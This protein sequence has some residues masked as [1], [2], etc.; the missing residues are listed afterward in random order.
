M[1]KEIGIAMNRLSVGVLASVLMLGA[2][3][4]AQAAGTHFQTA[5]IID[6]GTGDDIDGAATLTRTEDAV[7]ME[8]RTADLDKKAGYTTWWVIFNNPENCVDGCGMDDLGN[9]QVA[10]SIFYAG[11]FITGTDGAANVTAH[12]EAGVLAEGIDHFFGPGLAAGNGLEAECHAIV[13]SHGLLIAGLVADQ[14]GTI[15]G[16]CDVNP[17]EDQQAI[18]FQPAH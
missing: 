2:S 17:C 16:A 1:K 7:R 14:I 13:R 5:N 9:P 12:L 15:G 18:V 3:S 6:F 10:A 4:M 11:G 8:I